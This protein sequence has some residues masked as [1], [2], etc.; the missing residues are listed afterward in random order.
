MFTELSE[1]VKSATVDLRESLIVAEERRHNILRLNPAPEL[2]RHFTFLPDQHDRLGRSYYRRSG[3]NRK[4]P[5]CVPRSAVLEVKHDLRLAGEILHAALKFA[6]A[7]LRNARA[8][9]DQIIGQD[10]RLPG[11]D[12][13]PGRSGQIEF[14]KWGL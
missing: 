5:G 3:S 9:A 7:A 4:D 1:V 12:A 11:N 14:Q 8:L 10:P 13:N 2:S 6:K